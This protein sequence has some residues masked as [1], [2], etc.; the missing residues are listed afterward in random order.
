MAESRTVKFE[1]L[2]RY[3]GYEFFG[4]AAAYDNTSYFWN[5]EVRDDVDRVLV[6]LSLNQPAVGDEICKVDFS[7]TAGHNVHYSCSADFNASFNVDGIVTW[8]TGEVN[9]TFA[10]MP[11]DQSSWF[12]QRDL[13][14]VISR[15]STIAPVDVDDPNK[16]RYITKNLNIDDDRDQAKITLYPSMDPPVVCV[17]GASQTVTTTGDQVS[18]YLSANQTLQDPVKFYYKLEGDLS[19]ALSGPGQGVTTINAGD[20]SALVTFEY[21]GG[22][23]SDC[24]VVLDYERNSI[25]FSSY[26]FDE[27]EVSVG[28]SGNGIDMYAI[29]QAVHADQ[30]LSI[31]TNDMVLSGLELRTQQ[32]L[33]FFTAVPTICVHGGTQVTPGYEGEYLHDFIS[34]TNST[35]VTDPVTGNDLVF[36]VPNDGCLSS[37]AYIRESFDNAWCG[38]NR[39]NFAARRWQRS[40]LRIEPLLGTDAAKNSEFVSLTTRVRSRNRNHQVV[41]RMRNLSDGWGTT[42]VTLSASNGEDVSAS[43]SFTYSDGTEIWVWHVY[44]MHEDAIDGWGT[45]YGAFEDEHGKGIYMVHKVDPDYAYLPAGTV[46]Y[47]TIDPNLSYQALPLLR[48][49]EYAVGDPVDRRIVGMNGIITLSNVT[50]GDD[51]NPINRPTYMVQDLSTLDMLRDNQIGMPI[52]SKQWEQS[53]TILSGPPTDFWPRLYTRWTPRGNAT[54]DPNLTNHLLVSL[55]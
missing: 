36:M 45:W 6:T 7:G 34:Q 12:V 25:I 22:G 37:P 28:A 14:L 48:D 11:I 52:H 35:K 31:H 32:D 9:K 3:N 5:K 40:S 21:S 39:V 13:L 41:F 44:N 23:S 55:V 47:R 17:S 10:V 53:D 42:D 29:P 26:D 27:T 46:R 50:D 54:K 49:Y 1:P 51:I 19:G 4:T 16:Q 24:S 18:F 15:A 8:N 33:P 2:S 30:N 43:A 20:Y 38:G